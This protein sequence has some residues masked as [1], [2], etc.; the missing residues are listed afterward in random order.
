MNIALRIKFDHFPVP[1]RL[2]M[3][4]EA[5]MGNLFNWTH[6]G[7]PPRYPPFTVVVA[8]DTPFSF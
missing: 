6:A 7:D 8:A 5:P 4:V 2:I 3:D 1:S